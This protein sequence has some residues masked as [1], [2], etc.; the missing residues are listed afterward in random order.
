MTRR[1]V[2]IGLTIMGCVAYAT[3]LVGG[4]VLG[5]LLTEGL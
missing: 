4:V 2:D 3:A 5:Y 1:L